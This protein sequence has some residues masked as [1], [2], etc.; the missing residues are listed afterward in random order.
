LLRS[1]EQLAAHLYLC[2]LRGGATLL[3]YSDIGILLA[4][5]SSVTTASAHALLK[6]GRD[7]LAVRALIGL[8][9]TFALVPACFFVP[10]PSSAVLPWLVTASILH[11]TYQLVL[12][13]AYEANDFAVAYPIARGIAPIA[14][15]VLGVA[16][17]GEQITAAGFIGIGLVS[18]GI[19][20]IALRRSMVW[21]GLVAAMIAGVL[22]TAYTIVDAN[23]IRIASVAMTFVAWFFLLDGL[24]MFPI[25]AIARRGQVR[26]LLRSEGRQGVMAGVAS[27]ISFGTVLLALRLAPTGI[28]S[29]LRETSVVFG[30]LIAAFVLR[31]HV[32]RHQI[33]AAV[34]IATGAVL[35][36]ASTFF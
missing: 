18:A 1:Y 23:A 26:A 24:I 33:V 13:R 28:V 25:F 36:V 16:L 12:I 5:I 15:A 10:L 19:L 30:M 9:G 31:E 3:S 27:L 35:I 14:T 11:T 8:V 4:L 34:V 6:A 20:L 29:A 21:T 7:K 32:G 22:T 17:L 2:D